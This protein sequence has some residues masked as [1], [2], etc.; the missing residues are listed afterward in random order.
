MAA[1]P[2]APQGR[3]DGLA[4]RRPQRSGRLTGRA[5]RSA[6][7]APPQESGNCRRYKFAQPPPLTASGRLPSISGQPLGLSRHSPA[8]RFLSGCRRPGPDARS[9]APAGTSRRLRRTGFHPKTLPRPAGSGP[10]GRALRGWGNAP[11]RSTVRRPAWT[12]LSRAAAGRAIGPRWRQRRGTR[13]ASSRKWFQRAPHC[14]GTGPG[15]PPAG[16]ARSGRTCRP[17]PPSGHHAA[18]EDN[19][20]Q[21]VASRSRWSRTQVRLAQASPA[22]PV[23]ASSTS[24]PGRQWR[25]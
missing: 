23:G 17:E 20:E 3:Y 13:S 25:G 12:P 18:E 4:G 10:R 19:E 24:D 1:P 22:P 7:A 21:Q 11:C 16:R 15:Q 8:T 9:G 2:A 6:G 14:S 5:P